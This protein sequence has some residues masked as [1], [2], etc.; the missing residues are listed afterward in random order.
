MCDLPALIVWCGGGRILPQP[1]RLLGSLEGLALVLG[2]RCC[3]SIGLAVS[4]RRPVWESP[5]A[6]IP[7][8]G[9]C[10]RGYTLVYILC[11][12]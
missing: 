7:R 5:T 10:T 2:G 9:L 6:V 11:I 3:L 1:T 12:L 8:A 4:P